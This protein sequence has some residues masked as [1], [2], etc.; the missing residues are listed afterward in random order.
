M[1]NVI[2]SVILAAIAATGPNGSA[3]YTPPN[4]LPAGTHGDVI[5]ARPLTT[6]A[7]LPSAASN[8][9]VLYHT[10]S[11]SGAD[12]AVSGTISVPKG[13]PPKGGWP[14]ISWA[15]GTTGD[16]PQCTPSLDSPSG[17]EHVYLGMVEPALDQAVA[18]GY[19]VVQTDYEGQGTPG[20][21]PY[22]IGVAEARDAIDIVRAARQIVPQLSTSWVVM[23]HS[24][25]G[26]TVLFT[27]ATAAQWAPELHLIGAVAEAP[28]AFISVFIAGF[29]KLTTPTP[30][31]A[32]GA[33]FI[34][35]AASFDPAVKLDQIFTPAALAMVPQLHDR[36]V[37][38]LLMSPNSWGSIVPAS[39]FR[40][41]AVLAPLLAF[42]ATNDAGGLHPAVPLMLAQGSA[43]TTVPKASSDAIVGI[44]CGSGATIHYDVYQGI[45]HR[46]LVMRASDDALTWVG[47]RFAGQPA[48]TNCGGA[49][50]LH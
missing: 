44:L 29:P 8:T 23:G 45:E 40:T 17:P 42:A 27:S 39:S 33:L 1:M 38:A 18:R 43:D 13:A 46:P 2:S 34:D 20:P 11:L 14:V 10:T 15:H 30:A 6:G 47:A 16:A 21:A 31:Y 19:V 9:L 3:F 35:A 37:S 25:G 12:V 50:T 49:P 26:Q 22:L 28:A 24:Q 32:F 4:P 36:C 5:W 7:V 48:P 41:G